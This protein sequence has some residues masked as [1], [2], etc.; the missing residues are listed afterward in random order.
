MRSL[1]HEDAPRLAC[2][3]RWAVARSSDLSFDNP[4][5]QATCRHPLNDQ[6]IRPAITA[7]SQVPI[8]LVLSTLNSVGG[9]DTLVTGKRFKDR[10][11][12]RP[13]SHG[14]RSAFPSLWKHSA[15]RATQVGCDCTNFPRNL[16]QK[17]RDLVHQ[18]SKNG[19]RTLKPASLRSSQLDFSGVAPVPLVFAPRVLWM[20]V[21]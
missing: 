16:V 12:S 20:M 1:L 15:P 14:S 19:P 7:S 5:W 18:S 4:R 9:R 13:S 17:S 6:S 8:G 2:L 3:A 11:L 21:L 10:D